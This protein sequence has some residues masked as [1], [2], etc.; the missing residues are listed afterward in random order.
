LPKL[1]APP[2]FGAWPFFDRLA[3]GAPLDSNLDFEILRIPRQS[4]Q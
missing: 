4:G 1:F 3:M 2:R